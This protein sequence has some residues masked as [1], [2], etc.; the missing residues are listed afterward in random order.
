MNGPP[1]DVEAWL[2]FVGLFV[3][4]H[5]EARAAFGRAIAL[6]RTAAEA[7]HIRAQLDK[8]TTAAAG[9]AGRDG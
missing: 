6:A 7:G 5:P 1:R 2:I 8:L 9:H 3:C 4:C